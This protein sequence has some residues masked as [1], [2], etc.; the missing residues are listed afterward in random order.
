MNCR[1]CGKKVKDDYD[2]CP[3]CGAKIV[4]E[5]ICPKCGTKNELDSSFCKKCGTRLTEE[6]LREETKPTTTIAK[7][8]E[9]PSSKP[10]SNAKTK[11]CNVLSY[12]AMG[13]SMLCMILVLAFLF[14]PFLSDK[15]L[16]CGDYTVL[17]Y[18]FQGFKDNSQ[19]THSYSLVLSLILLMVFVVVFITSLALI[20]LSISQF[21]KA[22]QNQ[23]YKDFSKSLAIL[24]SIFLL[25]VV[26]FVRFI[27]CEEAHFVDSI[28]VWIILL[29]IFVGLTLSFNYL[30]NLL[31]KKSLRVSFIVL[32]ECSFVFLFSTLCVI[33]LLIGG[34]RFG[35]TITS[36]E[37]SSQAIVGH[38][39]FIKELLSYGD[40][41]N[42]YVAPSVIKS[43]VFIG[44]SFISEMIALSLCLALIKKLGS[45]KKR[46]VIPSLIIS[47]FIL[48]F[49]I[50]SIIFDAVTCKA[51]AE[52]NSIT[53]Y[54]AFVT[55]NHLFGNSL[56]KILVSFILVGPLS[57][58]WIT[59]N[60]K[61]ASQDE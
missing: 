36:K 49:F 48:T 11:K 4:R 27:I 59:L 17:H 60:K 14:I 3:N 58:L 43:L 51:I 10:V 38:F 25:L 32:L 56:A 9:E 40:K 12:I 52:I 50:A 15:F 31:S 30:L 57:Y 1:N 8:D 39:G 53:E 18:V 7:T 13:C 28:S 46:S 21:V 5:L 24:F 37:L 19:Y 33:T 16:P 23:E 6:Q 26:F 45:F 35:L 20:G 54:G 47:G 22:I 2:F 55:C 61:G 29:T 42:S 41:M 44:L 34:N